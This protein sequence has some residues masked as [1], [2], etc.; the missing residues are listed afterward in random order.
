MFVAALTVSLGGPGAREAHPRKRSDC[1]A[2]PC[3][4]LCYLHGHSHGHALL[5]ALG[6]RLRPAP[7]ES[8]PARM[9]ESLFRLSEE[10][11]HPVRNLRKGNREQ[12]GLSETEA[13]LRDRQAER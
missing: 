6:R 8:F 2:I 4:A 3:A 11:P 1:Y 13:R 7:M 12:R 10:R 9:E 5:G